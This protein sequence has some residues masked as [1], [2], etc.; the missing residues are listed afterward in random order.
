MYLPV[1]LIMAIDISNVKDHLE[2][3]LSKKEISLHV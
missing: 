2:R 3:R 1:S